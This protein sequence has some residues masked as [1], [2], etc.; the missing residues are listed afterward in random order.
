[1]RKKNLRLFY[2]AGTFFADRETKVAKIRTRKNL[3]PHGICNFRS[4]V[5]LFKTKPTFRLHSSVGVKTWRSVG[6]P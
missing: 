5:Y 1:L 3:V 4:A 2:F 6:C